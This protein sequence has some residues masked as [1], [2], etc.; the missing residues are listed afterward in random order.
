MSEGSQ[1]QNGR[2]P[3]SPGATPLLESAFSSEVFR[4]PAK[5]IL[6][7]NASKALASTTDLDQLLD[8]IVS[9]VQHVLGCGGAAVV[10]YDSTRDDFYWRTVQD[11]GGF[12]ASAREEIRI[13]RDQGV[14]GW[15]FNTGRPA[16]IHDGAEDP[17]IYKGVEEKSGLPPTNLVC[18]PMQTREKR[19]G[20]MYAL[21]KIGGRFTNEDVEIMEA[22]SSSVALALDNAAYYDSLLNSHRELERLNRVKNK[23]LHHLSHE[24]VTPLAIL[25]ASLRL[26]EKRIQ[27]HG[28]DMQGFP[29]ERIYR[30]LNRLKIIERQVAHIVEEKDFA[31]RELLFG[32]LEGLEDF[33]AIQQEEDP[34]L[35]AAMTSLR[36]TLE[37]YLPRR[38]EETWRLSTRAA[39]QALEYRVRTMTRQRVLSVEFLPPDPAIIRIQPQIMMSVMGGLVRNAI[40]NTPDHGKISVM[41]R[42]SES[43][44][45]I[46]VRDY[47][48]GIPKSEQLNIFE[49]FYPLQETEMYSS[50]SP[51]AFNAGG[52]GTDL[53]K[54]KV[55]SER[56]GFNIRFQSWRC[57]C[58]PT[59]RDVCPG[60]ITK[61]P[62]CSRP[63]DCHQ[64]GGTE[65]VVEIPP[66]LVEADESGAQDHVTLHAP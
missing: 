33:M 61:C 29:F 11:K 46:T 22:L 19:L 39:F 59:S 62:G 55:F 43:G 50:R 56:F 60:D 25:E 48:V 36:R 23:M 54:I 4:D 47:G 18:V 16:L 15:V 7:L 32:L 35:Q 51:Y 64:N 58:V 12:L 41:G 44:Y 30:N 2:D 6:L 37:D 63:E 8:V 31:Q 34:N 57:S 17:R 38:V 3:Q 42:N 66:A 49:G 10:V 21:N 52:T 14:A 13:P 40:E 28:L 26:M 45:A 1:I 20:V 5:L 53:L 9:E 65:F 27:T 24:L